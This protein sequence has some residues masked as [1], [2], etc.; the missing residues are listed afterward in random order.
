MSEITPEMEAYVGKI[1]EQDFTRTEVEQAF[2]QH[3]VF[4]SNKNSLALANFRPDRLRVWLDDDN[5]VVKVITG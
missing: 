3:D 5:K 1:Y 4:I 2:P